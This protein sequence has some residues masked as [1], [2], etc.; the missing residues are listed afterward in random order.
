MINF[1][2]EDNPYCD[3]DNNSII[4]ENINILTQ[5]SQQTTSSTNKKK[6]KATNERT[7]SKMNME[8]DENVKETEEWKYDEWIVPDLRLLCFKRKIKG[9][10]SSKKEWL[11]DVLRDYDN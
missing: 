4:D 10:V 9:Y 7:P 8:I 11:M 6:Q 3:D 1:L 2:A 5:T